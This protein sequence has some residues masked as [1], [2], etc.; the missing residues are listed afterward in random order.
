VTTLLRWRYLVL[1]LWALVCFLTRGSV[2]GGDWH[3]FASGSDLLFGR[4]PAGMPY[5][6]GLHLYA[7][8]PEYQIGP[9]A[10]A[11]AGF[12]RLVGGGHGHLVAQA[13]MCAAG[14]GVVYAVE[15]GA[16]LSR[17]L[18]SVQDEPWLGLAVLGGGLV[19]I[20]S[21]TD[22][23]GPIAH[24]DDVIA[25]AAAAGAVW[26]V[27]ARRPVWAGIAVGIAIAAKPWGVLELP[28]LAALGRRG[29]SRG[30]AASVATAGL[31]WLPFL[32]ADPV[33]I[34]A[35]GRFTIWNRADSALRVLGVHD[36]IAPGWLRPT[37]MALGILLALVAVRRGRWAGALLAAFA[38][39]LALDPAAWPYYTP[40][41]VLGAL[42]W[43]LL[44][45]RRAVPIW[46]LAAFIG[47]EGA[48]HAI[49]APGARGA[50]R[51]ALVVVAL[52]AALLV[53]RRRGLVEAAA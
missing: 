26:A 14:P 41:L 25:L 3:Y 31:A 27:A 38:V 17:R 47:L 10:L 24:V 18:R 7:N 23:A 12:F 16:V 4:H 19:F 50:E 32:I 29:A 53:P 49:G 22:V 11:L 43:D 20:R 35:S 36:S 9:L 8:Y 21:W 48:R 45:A 5:P 34:S 44:G 2:D 40:E 51:L 37:Q 30:F 42:V 6:G 28:L 46:T 33:S 15:R 1:G 13:C 39:R 52:G